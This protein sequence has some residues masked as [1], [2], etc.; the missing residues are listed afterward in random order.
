MGTSRADVRATARRFV[1]GAATEERADH[2]KARL[3]AVMGQV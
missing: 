2:L 3:G 1:G